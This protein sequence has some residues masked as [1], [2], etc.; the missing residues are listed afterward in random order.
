MQ[1]A[2]VLINITQSCDVSQVAFLEILER[3]IIFIVVRNTFLVVC[4]STVQHSRRE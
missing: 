4:F 2:D 3:R 1:S